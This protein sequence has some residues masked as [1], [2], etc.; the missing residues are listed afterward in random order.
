MPLGIDGDDLL[1][2]HC[3]ML[4]HVQHSSIDPVIVALG[5]RTALLAAKP[6]LTE[7]GFLLGRQRNG[8]QL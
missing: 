5:K 8:M 3:F 2:H 7:A 4:Q 1:R 6:F